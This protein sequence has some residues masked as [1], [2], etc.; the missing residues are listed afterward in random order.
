M[1]SY[2]VDWVDCS[3]SNFTDAASTLAVLCYDRVQS[4]ESSL[5]VSNVLI[6]LS[7]ALSQDVYEEKA[8]DTMAYE[9][10]SSK[11]LPV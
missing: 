11:S 6:N 5:L 7:H 3:A 4:G 10:I 8:L 2:S 1:S 9:E